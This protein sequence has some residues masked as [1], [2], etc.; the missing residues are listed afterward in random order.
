MPSGNLRPFHAHWSGRIDIGAAG[1]PI[2]ALGLAFSGRRSLEWSLFAG[3]WKLMRPKDRQYVTGL[4][5]ALAETL[6]QVWFGSG[7]VVWEIP[8]FETAPIIAQ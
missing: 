3:R 6:L 7:D 8:L 1:G 4:V 5:V 2:D